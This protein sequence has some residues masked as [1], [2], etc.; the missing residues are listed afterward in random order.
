MAAD[1]AGVRVGILGIGRSGVAAAKAARH[2]GGHPFV[3]DEKAGA[4]GS[5]LELRSLGIAAA[6]DW[7]GSFSS[8]NADLVVTSPGVPKDNPRLQ[9]ALSAGIEVI[10]E[11]ELA[12]RIAK[13]PIVALTGTNGKSTTTV[14]TYLCLESAGQRPILCGNIYGSGYEEMPLTEAAVAAEADQV[15]VAEVSSFQLDFTPTFRP[16]SAGI[17]NIWEDHLN[18]YGG[19]MA[20]Y[21]AVK[22]LIFAHQTAEDY[23]VVRAHDPVVRP[24]KGPIVLT[25]GSGG[26]HAQVETDQLIILGTRLA[27]KDL[28]FKEPHNYQNAAMAALLGYGYLRVRRDRDP[29]SEAARILHTAEAQAEATIAAR[30][31]VYS[32]RRPNQ[33]P[34]VAPPELLAGLK[35]FRGLSHRMEV[36]G[37]KSGVKVI[38]NSMCTNVDA[39][40]KS[41]TAIREPK[42]LLIGGVNKG[43]DFRPLRNY[44]ANRRDQAYLYGRDAAAINETLGGGWPVFAKLREAFDAAKAASKPGE[45]IMLSPGCASFDEFEDFRHRGNVFK[46]LAMEWLKS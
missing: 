23:A 29:G 1:L 46:E 15:L 26:E 13:A 40:L 27:A 19:S 41:A 16:V 37:D 31:S 18:R 22:H 3:V 34:W 38:N 44:L 33:K 42:H 2:A 12:Y 21:A 7:T 6:T 9:E 5:V 24:P 17:T 30:R 45:V 39:I 28:P 25:F 43:L 4:P 8:G 20:A 11:I 10:G 35:Q 32:Q 36:L 14:M